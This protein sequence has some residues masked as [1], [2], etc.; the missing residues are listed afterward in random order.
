MVAAI[1]HRLSY[2]PFSLISFR[3]YFDANGIGHP[4]E[5]R[6]RNEAKSMTRYERRFFVGGLGCGVYL[7]NG[8]HNRFRTLPRNVVA[9]VRQDHLLFAR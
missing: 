8:I 7:A 5:R 9:N 2:K 3:D 1:L 4:P 6:R